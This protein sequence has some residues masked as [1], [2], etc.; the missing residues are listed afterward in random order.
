MTASFNIEKRGVM[1]LLGLGYEER[2]K[3]RFSL[4]VS[5]YDN[6]D[7]HCAKQAATLNELCFKI[8][9]VRHFYFTRI[10]E[11]ENREL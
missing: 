1:C 3:T 9:S 5:S 11:V 10:C 6:K 8:L 4:P 2:K 7:Q